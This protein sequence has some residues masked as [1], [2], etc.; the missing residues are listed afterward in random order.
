V[1]AAAAM[2]TALPIFWHGVVISALPATGA[3]L[4]CAFAV[5]AGGSAAVIGLRL[6]PGDVAAISGEPR[7][8]SLDAARSRHSDQTSVRR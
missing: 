1:V 4:T 8:T 6:E 3:R 7:P 5:L 2:I